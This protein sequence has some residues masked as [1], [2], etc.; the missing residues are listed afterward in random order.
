MGKSPS[1]ISSRGVRCGLRKGERSS[2]GDTLRL[3]ELDMRAMEAAKAFL[4]D[5]A[6]CERGIGGCGGFM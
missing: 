2:E 3:W 1:R 5:S 4:G 6:S